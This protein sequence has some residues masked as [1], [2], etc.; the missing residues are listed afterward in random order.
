MNL[1]K[2]IRVGAN[3]YEIKREKGLSS[4]EAVWGRIVYG[5]TTIS[6]DESLSGSLLRDTLAHELAH[7]ILYEAG[8][9]DHDEEQANRI[10]KVVTMLLRDNNFEFMRDREAVE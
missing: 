9:E 4:S 2:T 3:D 5:T 10:G 8:Y 1:P 6:L 7:A